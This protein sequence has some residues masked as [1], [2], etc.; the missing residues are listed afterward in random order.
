[1]RIS[2][3]IIM[4]VYVFLL[5]LLAADILFSGR[6]FSWFY[7]LPV[8]L[9]LTLYP[10]VCD[11]I[12]IKKNNFLYMILFFSGIITAALGQYLFLVLP[13][14]ASAAGSF[15][16]LAS[17]FMIISAIVLK[18]KDYY[19]P[20]YPRD[21]RIEIAAAGLL[22]VIAFALRIYAIDK[23]PVGVWFDEA[24][25]GNE[26]IKMLKEN[27]LEVFIPRHTQMPAM[28]F[29]I[30]GL[31][32]KLF[33]PEVFS[34]RFVSVFT[35]S[36]SI[37]AFFFLLRYVLGDFKLAL[38]GA[39][40]LAFSRWH[41]TFSRVGFLGMQTLFIEILFV[42]FYLRT[43]KEK[44]YFYAVMAGLAGGLNLYTFSA[45]NLVPLAAGMHMAFVFIKKPSGFIAEKLRPAAVMV[46]VGLIVS[47]PLLIYAVNNS[48]NVTRRINDVGIVKDIKKE[49]SLY[50]VLK[51]IYSYAHTFHLAG[52]YN[53]RHNLYKKPLLDIISG[54]LFAA[55]FFAAFAARGGG[56]FLVWFL[57]M[58]LPGILT[59][60]IEAPQAYRIIGAIPPLYILI[61]FAL[62][63]TGSFLYALKKNTVY[64]NV[65]LAAAVCCAGIININQ[66]FVIYPKEKSA[67]MDFSPGPTNIAK[68]INEK[69]DDYY[70]FVSKADNMYGFYSWEQ[71]A[72][73]KFLT[74]NK[75]KFRYISEVNGINRGITEEKKGAA[76]VVRPSDE[77]YIKMIKESFP[78]ASKEKFV[79]DFNGEII[80]ICYYINFKDIP[81]DDRNNLIYIYGEE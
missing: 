61:M 9:L 23:I 45:A 14:D 48:E 40:L 19:K 8:I 20:E 68:L 49:K 60:T 57:V 56:F 25:N 73:L 76:I 47:G 78:R 37:A 18:K 42:Y 13:R 70:F 10:Y 16:F 29:W 72:M 69:S 21:K 36:L 44:R 55:G 66:Y 31:F 4:S 12:Q 15:V 17:A 63:E 30:S 5:S 74:Y 38:A 24:Q 75:G 26:V 39:F 79:N 81:K 46:L 64:F 41:I 6:A 62:R 27:N 53:G 28:F 80:F 7:L 11:D 50:P 67:F 1:M 54:I 22:F 65:F 58:M 71:A 59:I 77:E 34:L 3:T 35:G 52:D 33:G 51:N 32:F 43:I 2:R